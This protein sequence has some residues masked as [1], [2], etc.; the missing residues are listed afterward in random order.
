M[1]Y[2]NESQRPIVDY[3][4][5]IN[6]INRPAS[7]FFVFL[8]CLVVIANY[9]LKIYF[10]RPTRCLIFI[11]YYFHHF[12]YYCRWQYCF[13]DIWQL[14]DA[15]QM[16]LVRQMKINSMRNLVAKKQINCIDNPEM[17][18]QSS[19]YVLQS[20]LVYIATIFDQNVI[21]TQFIPW[22]ITTI[23]CLLRFMTI[24]WIM[25]LHCKI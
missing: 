9:R 14:F 11:A 4:K 18:A 22:K 12:R 10:I 23:T 5:T 25:E 7:L 16:L 13:V 1:S 21:M 19:Y 3:I 17:E 8:N 15:N 24:N 2:F 20:V 6:L